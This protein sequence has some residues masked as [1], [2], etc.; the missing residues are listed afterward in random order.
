M[1]DARAL[2]PIE[3]LGVPVQ[4]RSNDTHAAERL[5]RCYERAVTEH[6]AGAEVLEARLAR[7]GD[8]WRIEVT[9]R[10]GRTA[11]DPIHAVRSLNHELVHGVMLRAPKLYYVHAG[12]VAVGG[13]AIVLP[14]LSRAGKST[15]VLGLIEQGAQLLSDELL[16]FDPV[17]RLARVFPRAIKIRDACVGYFPTLSAHFHG[18]GEGRF[19]AFEGLPFALISAPAPVA[20]IVVP[21]WTGSGREELEPISAGRALLDLAGSS[22]NFGTHRVRSLDCLAAMVD[23]ARAWRL[24]WSDPHAAAREIMRAFGAGT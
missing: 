5:E 21:T 6:P 11:K 1:P 13:Q 16:A 9:G 14:G 20:A 18:A 23:E 7:R 17:S 15:L 12:V 3:L 24:R 4:L 10:A 2:T 8:A 22:L 19:L